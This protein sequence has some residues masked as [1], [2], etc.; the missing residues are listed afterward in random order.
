M[1]D[2]EANE[3]INKVAKLIQ[4][5]LVE[6]HMAMIPTISLQ[7]VPEQSSILTP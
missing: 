2:Q 1:T 5:I 4:D 3:K 7:P 6:N